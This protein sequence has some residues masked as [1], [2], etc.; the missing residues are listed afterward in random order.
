MSYRFA[1]R[2]DAE[3]EANAIAPHPQSQDTRE[4]PWH[5]RNILARKILVTFF[6]FMVLS[7]ASLRAVSQ[8]DHFESARLDGG[9]GALGVPSSNTP[10]YYP[11]QQPSIVSYGSWPY[12]QRG[13]SVGLLI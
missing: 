8:V 12:S 4:A 5:Y 2:G 10:M 11:T 13:K 3:E 7:A 6:Q 9:G 1:S